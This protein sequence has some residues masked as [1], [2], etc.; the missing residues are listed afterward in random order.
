MWEINEETKSGGHA[1]DPLLLVQTTD[2]GCQKSSAEADLKGS[3]ELHHQ[4]DHTTPLTLVED[5]DF[6]DMVE[7][8]DIK[9]NHLIRYGKP[10]HNIEL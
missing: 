10:N 8:Q 1:G 4:E 5:K 3:G 7:Q 2:M 6:R 9:L